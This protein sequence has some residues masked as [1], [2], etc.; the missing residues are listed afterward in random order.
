MIEFT[1]LGFAAGVAM[2]VAIA[3]GIIAAAEA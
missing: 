1:T 3:G 2:G